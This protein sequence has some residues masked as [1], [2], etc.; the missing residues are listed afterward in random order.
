M[1]N[2]LNAQSITV[3]QGRDGIS[4][5]RGV[6]LFIYRIS[7][8][9]QPDYPT[10]S[11]YK[12]ATCN[13]ESSWV[14]TCATDDPE[15]EQKFEGDCLPGWVCR[16]S[17]DHEYFYDRAWCRI[18]EYNFDLARI[19]QPPSNAGRPLLSTASST[20]TVSPTTTAINN[21]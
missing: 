3:P 4:V 5:K 14:L 19:P 17:L 18:P 6:Q 15:N 12:G 1:I 2:L 11:T 7:N 20:A 8:C 10:Y 16:D 9:P 13:G 21:I